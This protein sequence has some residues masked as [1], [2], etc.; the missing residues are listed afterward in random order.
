MKKIKIYFISFN[1][2]CLFLIGIFIISF[3]FNLV[4]NFKHKVSP[5]NSNLN[6]KIVVDPGHGGIDSGANHGQVLEKEINLDIA[7]KVVEQLAKNNIKAVLTRNS[8]ELYN[9]DRQQD[10]KH[11]VEVANNSN[12][13]LLIS[14]HVNSFPSSKSFGGETYYS[15]NSKEGKK[16]AS[17]IQE[18]LINIQPKNYRTIKTAPYYVLQNTKIPAVL[19]EVGFISNPQDRKRITNSNEQEKIAKAITTGIINYFNNN[20]HLMPS[21]TTGL[22]TFLFETKVNKNKT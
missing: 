3:T 13:N 22:F 6:K 8:D 14:I 7:Q 16:L 2:I 18:Q 5:V 15:K 11:R 9:N 21:E 4:L 17:A 1:K 20:L 10:L 12:A 19:I